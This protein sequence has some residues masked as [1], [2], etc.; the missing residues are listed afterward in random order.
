MSAK[1]VDMHRLQE[2]VRLHRLGST[3]R[4][5]ARLLKMGRN[6]Q[7]EYRRCLEK[8]GLLDGDP[9][10]LPELEMLKAAVLAERPPVPPPQQS[11]TLESYRD[12]ISKMLDRGAGPKSIYDK[13]RLDHEDFKASLSAVKRLCTRLQ[14][15]K[16]IQP[17]D[18][19][20]PVISEPGEIAQ[21]DFGYVGKVYDPVTRSLRKVWAFV[22]VLAFSR[23]MIARLVFDQT[24]ETWQQ[25]HADVFAELGGVVETVVPDNLKAAVIRASFG[26][27][28][29]TQLNRS[30]RELARH[31]GFKIDPAPVR[32]PEKKGKVESGVRYLRRNFLAPREFRDIHHAREE[33]VAWLRE[34]AGQRIHGTT[35]KRPAEVFQEF[36]HTVLKPLPQR[37]YEITTWR[38]AQVHQDTHVLFGRRFY[39]VPWK[40]IGQEVWIRA[41]RSTVAIYHDD[42]RVATH[43]RK[44]LGTRSTIEAHLPTHRADLRYRSPAHWQERA[45]RLGVEVGQY[46]REVFE[47]DDVLSQLKVVQAVVR[48]LETVPP[49]RA[50]A[51]CARASLYGAYS[52]QAI[53]RILEKGLDLEPCQDIVPFPTPDLVQ[54]RYARNFAEIIPMF[55]GQ[56]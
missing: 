43:D 36:E 30:Y 39:S 49:E 50:R 10:D 33:L 55:G 26:I 45:D 56:V 24:A 20:I 16:G 4:D 11:S 7:R 48:H 22:M 46:A 9:D 19:A 41:T 53:K 13:L 12:A 31:Y 44:G 8:A 3:S 14:K 17:E 40:L 42:E 25:L 2:F 21:V 38:K 32:A 18:V 15:D 1:R 54:P 29:P 5:L 47:S 27:D 52:F 51:A 28:E 34:V 35:G 37:R 6:T 23:H